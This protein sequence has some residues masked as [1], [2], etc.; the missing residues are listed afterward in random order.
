MTILFYHP[1]S[2]IIFQTI[3]LI[4]SYVN[5]LLISKTTDVSMYVSLSK[6]KNITQKWT[7]RIKIQ[8]FQN[9]QRESEINDHHKHERHDENVQA[10]LPP[11][12]DANF[13]L[14]I[15]TVPDRVRLCVPPRIVVQDRLRGD[16]VGVW[17]P[18]RNTFL[19]NNANRPAELLSVF[20]QS[21]ME[22]R[23]HFSFCSIESVLWQCNSGLNRIWNV[24]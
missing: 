10:L 14:T 17:Y 13:E 15:I 1:V 6:S 8:Y 19:W 7:Y 18:E 11:A 4:Y 2:L 21:F 5:F 24:S 12:V 9:P 23:L 22:P 16:L 20:I 3:K